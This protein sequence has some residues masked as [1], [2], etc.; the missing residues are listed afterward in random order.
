M[1]LAI[2]FWVLILLWAV[3]GFWRGQ[4]APEPERRYYIG[5]HFLTFVLLLLLGWRV[6]GGP[7]Q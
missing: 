7:V 6:F 1:T 5:G 3:F 4:V 2:W